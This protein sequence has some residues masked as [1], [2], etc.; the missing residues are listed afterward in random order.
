[1]RG[2]L[3]ADRW[4][5]IEA[6]FEA[7]VDLPPG[8]REAFLEGQC[9]GDPELHAE[10]I[11][12]L[13]FDLAQ[14]PPLLD[15]IHAGVASVL[16]DDPIA[17]QMLG[18][19]R[20]ER[21]I[22]RGGMSVVYLAARADGE[23]QKRVAV[24]LIKRGMDTASVIQRL[25]RER[26]I[27]AGLEH[28][29]IAH[30]LDGGTTAEGLPWIA[31]EF[32]EGLP[33]NRFC[34]ERGL[35]IEERC[36]LMCKVCDAVAYAHRNLVVHRDLKPSNILIAPDGNP[37]L[38]DF[39]IAKL[40]YEDEM[41]GEEPLTRGSSVL[42][43]PEY[44]SP[45][46][47][48]RAPATTAS[49]VYSLGVVLYELLTGERPYR[50]A[51]TSWQEM[52]RV[53][54]GTEPKKPST[55]E[56]LPARTR[57]RLAGD[58]DNIVLMAMRKDVARRYGL[59]EQLA[60]DLR[61]HFRG[62]PVHARRDTL[63][64][65]GGKFLRR[66]WTAAVAGGLIAASVAA[67]TVIAGRQA[68][69]ARERFE[70]LRGFA[71]T[72]LVDV[73]TQLSDIP[74]TAKARQTLVAYVD[75]YLR[76]VAA[77]RAGDDT[78]LAT[79]FATTYL[80]LGEMQ[81]VTPQ[82]I[83][84]FESGRRLLES[85]GKASPLDSSDLLA[86]ARLRVRAGSALLD[87]GQIQSGEQ[88]LAAAESLA[89][90]AN[91]RS[92]W[93]SEAELIK[94]F[95]EWRLARLYRM[96]Y[97]LAEGESH[98]RSAIATGEEVLRR[99]FRTKEAYETVNGARNVLAAVLRRQGNW[100]QSMEVYQKVL[101]DTEQRA[102]AE[103]ESAGLQRDLARSHQL[104]GDMVVRVP[105]HDENQVRAHVRNA[106]AIAERLATMDPWD[107]TAQSELAQYLSSGAETLRQPEEWQEGMS[108]LRRALPILE[109]LLKSEPGNGVYLQYAALTEADMGEFLARGSFPRQGVV[110]LR[111]GLSDLYKLA[112]SDPKNTT[113]LLEIIKV[114]R[115]LFMV[116]AH[117]GE[118]SEA[119]ALAQDGI[120][121]AR[122]VAGNINATPESWRELPRA[123]SAMADVYQVLRKPAEA[124]IWYRVAAAEWDKMAAKGLH[125]PD[126]EQEIASAAGR[127]ARP[128]PGS[129]ARQ[130]R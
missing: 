47:I 91:G 114:Q 128:V 21:E 34:D 86:L 50:L 1:M 62:L 56:A 44:A 7:G 85:K 17:G 129:L 123:Y 110:W 115:W 31:M 45:E 124:R 81:G 33:I 78:A 42:L 3:P 95:A 53:V 51:N 113:N 22:G 11:S 43:T 57:R 29:S 65:R 106:I 103:P 100:Q 38:L 77:Q 30:L 90:G 10:V 13:Q 8:E 32:I 19:Y 6:I 111:R 120:G 64:Y 60:N 107:K 89:A 83:A 14:E 88:S 75:D 70:Q 109:T 84:S 98:A 66:N 92:G 41:D 12:L 52:E 82:A 104:L 87:L 48:Q 119:I 39:G 117:E 4:T 122:K 67:G 118:E 36:L 125:F 23:F 25:R 101:A 72:V 28:P 58:L 9:H 68:L 54:C 24:K 46:Q 18:P 76:H 16:G 94:A 74:G 20:I 127:A 116:L 102:R 26:R 27:L 73:N 15:A 69:A 93:N 99:G 79:E 2:P 80:R 37:K 130:L 126:S 35:S 40:L 61:R 96:Q 112:E 105:G 121:K 97:R 5:Q 63:L 59:A 49:D 55:A 71:R 108:Y